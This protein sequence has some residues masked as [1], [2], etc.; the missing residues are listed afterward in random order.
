L[1]HM[2]GEL[3]ESGATQLEIEELEVELGVMDQDLG[4][5]NEIEQLPGD[6]GEPRLLPQVLQRHAVHAGRAQVDVAFRIQIDVEMALR[7]LPRKDLHTAD[8]D[9]AV[10]ELGIEPGGFSVQH[11]LARHCSLESPCY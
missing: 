3:A 8:F 1:R 5:G 7:D 6:L 10:A 9:D 11:Y 4:A 2:V